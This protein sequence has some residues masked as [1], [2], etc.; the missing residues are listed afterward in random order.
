MNGGAGEHNRRHGAVL[1]RVCPLYVVEEVIKASIVS[2]ESR[3]LIVWRRGMRRGRVRRPLR[4]W[5][6]GGKSRVNNVSLRQL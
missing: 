5:T 3:A 6:S 4:E 1:H 2:I